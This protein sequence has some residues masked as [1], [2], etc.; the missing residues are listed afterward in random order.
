MWDLRQ[1]FE[2]CMERRIELLRGDVEGY[3][4]S[5]G[6]LGRKAWRLPP[7][8]MI[9]DY[10]EWDAENPEHSFPIQESCVDV[11]H[12]YH[13]FE[14]L[15]G[16]AVIRTLAECDRCLVRGGVV[17][18]VVPYYNSQ[19]Q[20]TDLTH[21]TAFCEETWRN[22]FEDDSYRRPGS[23]EKWNLRVGTNVIMGVKERNL[24]LL[25]QLVKE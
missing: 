21:R 19:L 9:L 18:I 23:P 5:L 2:I 6:G 20:A 13:F 1:F 16:P 24:A 7:V 4:V 11:F 12:A 3:H 8:A 10:P 25:T 22:L 17:N 14:H 15:S